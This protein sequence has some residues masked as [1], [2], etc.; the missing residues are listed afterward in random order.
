MCKRCDKPV[1]DVYSSEDENTDEEAL[2]YIIP[3]YKFFVY[4]YI[5]LLWLELYDSYHW[6]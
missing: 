5:D 3:V 4:A 1:N 6:V 2:D